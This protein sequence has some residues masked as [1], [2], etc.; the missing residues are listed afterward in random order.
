MYSGSSNIRR[1]PVTAAWSEQVMMTAT[2]TE[3][4]RNGNPAES[5]SSSG[6]NAYPSASACSIASEST[7]SCAFC[8]GS[9]RSRVGQDR[10]END[11][12]RF[13]RRSVA[14]GRRRETVVRPARAGWGAQRRIG[15]RS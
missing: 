7:A 4:R 3:T 1:S 15:G 14:G 6:D 10:G 12:C 8:R 5:A 11:T 9:G 2:V 13:R